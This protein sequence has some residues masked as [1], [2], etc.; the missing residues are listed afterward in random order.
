MNRARQAGQPV[1]D[2]AWADQV[3]AGVAAVVR[4][5]VEAGVD[6]VND[7]EYGKAN[8]LVYGDE[9]LAGFE[10]RAPVGAAPAPLRRDFRE[11]AEFYQEAYPAFVGGGRLAQPM[12]T[13]PISYKGHA[14]LQF[15]IDNLRSAL[16]G[17]EV[18]EAFLP[19]IAPGTFGRGQNQ[20]YRT[21]EE[22]LFAIGAALREEYRA[23]VE[24]GFILQIDD[25][26]LPD[27]WDL[28]DPAPSVEEYQKYAAVRIEALNHALAGIPEDRVRYHICWGSWAGPHT[29]DLP[30][31]HIIDIL[32]SVRAGAYSVEAANVRHEHEWK[33]WQDV[34]L[35]D[36]KILMP[37]VVTHKTNVVEHPELVAD[38]IVQYAG[39]V[40]RENVIAGTDCGLGGRS[41]PQVAWAKLRALR[42]GADLATK[43]LW[44]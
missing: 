22:F 23:I 8:F 24:A 17:V 38:R 19:A 13:G 1:D 43:Q 37:G 20:Y 40:G 30:L 34:R 15:D 2:G 35:P 21:E 18:A 4:Q 41:H 16:A 26:G 10:R 12:C 29:T 33:V 5:Q 39:I 25:P 27:T 31:R 36:G 44:H 7:G 11:F 14:A 28:L 6:I 32:L 3:R 42:E 9:R